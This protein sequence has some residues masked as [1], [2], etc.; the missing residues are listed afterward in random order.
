MH[1]RKEL[2]L[3]NSV[4]ITFNLLNFPGD[5]ASSTHIADKQED[6]ICRS[7]ERKNWYTFYDVSL[8]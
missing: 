7:S 5:T 1:L 3:F 4:L 6:A 8:Y 2:Q